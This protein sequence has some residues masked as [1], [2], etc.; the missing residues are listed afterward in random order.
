[1]PVVVPKTAPAACAAD[2]WT[3]D[4]WAACDISGNQH[5]ACRLTKN[6]A[7]VTTNAPESDRP[8]TELQCGNKP[9]LRDRVA[10]RLSLD[11]VGMKRELEI[12]FLPE[13]CRSLPEGAG[14]ASCVQFY[15]DIQ[16]CFDPEGTDERNACA[17]SIIKM[18]ADIALEKR[19]CSTRGA[20]ACDELVLKVMRMVTF[21]IYDLEERAEDMLRDGKAPEGAVTNIVTLIE[22]KKAELWKAGNNAERKKIV[23]EIR[24]AYKSFLASL[25]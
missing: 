21:R 11:P 6:C 22:E 23:L 2:E 1:M 14:R 7:T 20:S 13:L 12:Q 17:S 3:C 19:Q 24:E 25:N 18:P 10:C 5:R 8:C 9:V 16:P 4:E 15:K